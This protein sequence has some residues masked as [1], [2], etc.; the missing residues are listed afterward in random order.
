MSL[1]PESLRNPHQGQQRTAGGLPVVTPELVRSWVLAAT[2]DWFVINKPAGVA[3]HG[4]GPHSLG[5]VLKEALG[6]DW[7]EAAVRQRRGWE[8]KQQGVEGVAGARG[9]ETATR[10]QSRLQQQQQGGVGACSGS[11]NG[12]LWRGADFDKQ[13]AAEREVRKQGAGVM[14]AVGAGAGAGAAGGGQ[15]AMG[16]EASRFEEPRPVHRLD[17]RTS[18][19]LMVARNA[20]AAAWLSLCFRGRTAAA[21]AGLD[22]EA[23]AAAE[24]QAGGG[25]GGAGRRRGRD[26][27]GRGRIEG[28]EEE[29][30][31]LAGFSVERTYYAGEVTWGPGWVAPSP[32]PSPCYFHVSSDVSAGSITHT[33]QL[34]APSIARYP[35]LPLIIPAPPPSLSCRHPRHPCHLHH[36]HHLHHLT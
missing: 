35:T 28:G 15:G 20:D 8:S 3:V 6:G 4:P 5:G 17:L 13:P 36:P 32:P 19:C 34:R 30:G 22:E 16:F 26:V 27:G 21:A 24:R 7:W 10:Q 11:V 31:V 18:G 29:A 33:P 12:G 25:K 9:E 23:A 14:A 2:R 1:S